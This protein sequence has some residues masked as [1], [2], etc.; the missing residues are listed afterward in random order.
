MMTSSKQTNPFIAICLLASFLLCSCGQPAN[1]FHLEAEFKNINQGEF[2]IY[3]PDTG[4][5]DTVAVMDGRFSYLLTLKDTVTLSILFPNYSELPVFATPATEVKMEGDVSHLRD[6]K[7]FGSPENDLMTE[8]RMKTNEKTPPEVE[9]EAEKF[10]REHTSSIVSVYLL[11]RYFL[12]SYIPDYAKAT[13][14]C[15]LLNEAQPGNQ[16]VARLNLQLSELKNFT[17]EGK[18][19]PPFKAVTTKGDTISNAMLKSDVN[20]IL[21]WAT[22]SYESQGPLHNL[23]ELEKKN[24]GRISVVSIC[25]DAAPTEA[26]RILERDS[27]QWPNVCDSLL[28]KSP[29]LAQL[30][31]ATVPA[32]IITDKKGIVVARNLTTIKLKEKIEELLKP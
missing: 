30:G 8:F 27:L 5:K 21:A 26:E 12:Q 10:I 28:W 3:N 17:R 19:L 2:Y 15:A 4:Q 7:I 22:W 9:A 11:R 1:R 29:I 13:E 18:K 23:R 16:Y 6:T 20:I 24:K 32:N 25:L 14:L 31:I